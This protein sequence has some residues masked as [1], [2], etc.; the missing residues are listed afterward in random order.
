MWQ[1]IFWQTILVEPHHQTAG[2]Q[3]GGTNLLLPR[4]WPGPHLCALCWLLQKLWTR[5]TQVPG[6]LNSILSSPFPPLQVQDEHKCGRGVLWLWRH[7]GLERAPILCHSCS[8]HSGLPVY[9]FSIRINTLFRLRVKTHWPRCR[10][11]FSSEQGEVGLS[12]RVHLFPYSLI[13]MYDISP[14][15]YYARYKRPVN[16]HCSGMF[17]RVCW[18]MHMSCSPSTHLWSCLGICRYFIIPMQK[19]GLFIKLLLHWK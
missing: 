11:T 13:H 12:L 2:V 7:R 8:G 5:R 6:M 10:L 15:Y 14:L 16:V 18:N 9:V 4:L 17:S 1:G 3:N 19:N